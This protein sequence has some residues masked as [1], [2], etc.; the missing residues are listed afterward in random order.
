M[1]CQSPKSPLA[2]IRPGRTMICYQRLEMRR[3][4][5]LG[6]PDVMSA[7]LWLREHM[8]SPYMCTCVITFICNTCEGWGRQGR[9]FG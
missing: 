7:P 3:R 4:E 5:I 8:S 1:N 6:R 9:Q 2:T